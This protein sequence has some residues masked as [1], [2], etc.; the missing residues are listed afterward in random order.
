MFQNY[1]ILNVSLQLKCFELNNFSLQFSLKIKLL[2][3]FEH[4][5]RSLKDICEK[6]LLFEIYI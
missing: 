3:L 2:E 4:L 1:N 5:M 6:K